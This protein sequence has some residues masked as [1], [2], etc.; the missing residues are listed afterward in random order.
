MRVHLLSS[1]PPDD[2]DVLVRACERRTFAPGETLLR[3]GETVRAMY[4]V[5]EGQG[6]LCRADIDLG[7]V[8]PGD[9]VGELGLIAGRPRAATLVAATPMTVDLLDQPRWHA[10]TTD[11]PRTATLFVEALVSAL[12]TQLTEM[13]DSVGVLLR[14]RS[15][16]R[17][18]SVEVELG[19]ERRAVRT[20]TLL[21]DL[22]AREVEGAPVVAALLDNKAVS[23]RAPITASGRIA[24][25]TTA[26][27]EGERVVRESTILLALE[28]AAR[29]ADLRVRVIASMGNASWLS[30]DGQDERDALPPSYRDGSE[31]E[32]PRVASLRAEMLALVARDLPFREEW[33]T[34]EEARA[35]LQEQGW[36]HAVDLLETA[37]EATV[38]MVSCGKVQALRM[39]PLVPTTGMLAGFAL[40]AT[41]D[42]A[43]LVTGAP[44]QD[45]GRSAWAD[46]MNEHGRWLAGLGVTSVGAFNRGCIDGNVSE[47][48]RVAEGFHEKR[49]GKIAD[50]IAAREGRVRVVGI[51]GPSSSGKTT[52]IKRLKVQLTLV[53][54][55]PVAVSLDDYYV[56]RV[57]TPKDT[58]GEYDYEA[59]EALDLPLLRDHVRRL[60]RGE[61]VKTARYDFVSGKSD[62]SGGPEITLGPRRVLMLEG[63]HGLNPRLLG[64]AVPSA[65]TFRVF[66]QPM[67]ALP[68]DDASRVSPSDL[69]LLRRIV[70]DRRGRGCS[71]G[72]N[73]LRWPSVRRGE[74]LHIFPFVDQADVV[75]DTSLVYELSV[76]KTY[77]ERYLLEVPTEHPAHPTANR[78][79]QLVDRF[80]AIHAAH[81]PPTSILREFIGESAFE[82]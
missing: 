22:L 4:F 40:Q 71:P 49:L 14:E 59:L 41:E 36:Q 27:F 58:R 16:P 76:L 45:L 25:L 17:R 23:L 60:L 54:I 47:T 20:G 62:P 13:T 42:G 3:E 81:V 63:I 34:L 11:A 8:G 65:Q 52:F 56:D 53:G 67:L 29:V 9:H 64:D 66:I 24:P 44:P 48:I 19:A 30:F 68:Y 37:R 57:R 1:L 70:R 51:A 46:V 35:Q 28:A 39:G 61:T 21:S 79:R 31:G 18:T 78:L 80:V 50:S 77:A 7:T 6:R 72:D 74:R 15:V 2:R 33:W 82:Y 26:Q 32:A 73:I 43:V 69:R 75:F 38:R 5:V 55:D 10:L 12:G